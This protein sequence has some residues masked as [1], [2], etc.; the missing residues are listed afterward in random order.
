MEL[1]ACFAG[2]WEPPRRIR[3]PSIVVLVE[4]RF[5]CMMAIML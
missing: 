3:S 5:L 1:V 4:V 2:T